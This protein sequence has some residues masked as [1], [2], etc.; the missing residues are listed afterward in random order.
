MGQETYKISQ[1]PEKTSADSTDLMEVSTLVD[2][3]YESKKIS[4]GQIAE[5]AMG[6][7]TYDDLTTTAKTI[8]GAI[9]ELVN[10]EPSIEVE[11]LSVTENGIYT[12]EEGKAYSPVTVNVKS[13]IEHDGSTSEWLD[14][15]SLV[16]ITVEGNPIAVNSP[17]SQNAISTLLSYSPKQSGSGD[18]SP[19]N[20][21]PIEGWTGAQITLAGK[22]YLTNADI[23]QGSFNTS[24]GNDFPS[25]TRI[26]TENYIPVGNGTYNI[27]NKQHYEY[28][29]YVYDTD[30][31]FLADESKVNWL[32]YG[33]TFT[34]ITD[35]LVRIAWRK[36]DNTTIT[37]SEISGLAC[38]SGTPT[39]YTVSWQTATAYEPYTQGA[40]ITESLGGTYYGFEIDVERGVLRVNRAKIEFTG[41]DEETWTLYS[42]DNLQQ[43]SCNNLAIQSVERSSAYSNIT[44]YGITV[45][46][47][48]N[49]NYGC[50]LTSG[51]TIISFQMQGSRATF[52]TVADWKSYL[53]EMYAN[54]TPVCAVYELSTPIELPLTPQT[55]ALLAGNNTLW[56][57][58]DNIEITYRGEPVT[59]PLLGML[60][61]AVL[62]QSNVEES[63]PTDEESNILTEEEEEN[64]FE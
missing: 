27:I 7:M 39:V 56:T 25:T 53:A 18:P 47:R 8:V 6:T 21:R 29:L 57:D 59:T 55:V 1:L 46:T 26:R 12:A 34:I 31:T 49:N 10:S 41:G 4:V 23:Q 24:T 40:T 58:G 51:G 63:E 13:E 20:I 17:L 5:T 44:P 14:D 38:Y 19:Q 28:V 37:P 30:G 54:G 48:Q 50:Y 15:S 45:S 2:S 11:P 3:S 61:N 33:T 16:P 36:S 35:R 43:F 60:G 64:V 22:N 42:L 32:A 52:G 62:T 9:N